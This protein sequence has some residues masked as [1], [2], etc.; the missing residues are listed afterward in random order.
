MLVCFNDGFGWLCGVVMLRICV[1]M[2][3]TK[4]F[5]HIQC[6]CVSKLCVRFGEVLLSVVPHDGGKRLILLYRAA[7]SRLGS[8]SNPARFN[9]VWSMV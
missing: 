8:V 7:R 5:C 2:G 9:I 6:V 1:R 4:E 3:A